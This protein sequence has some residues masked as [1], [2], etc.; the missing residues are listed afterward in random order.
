MPI[1]KSE[2]YSSLWKSCDELRGGMDASQYKDY[3]LVLLFVKYVSDKYAGQPDALIEVP[4]GG[5]FA[6]MI[7]LKG[8]KEIG[9]KVNKIIGKLAE[10]NELKGV[11]DV[12]DFNDA[13]KLGKGKEMVDRLSNLIAIFETPGLDFSRNRAEGDDILGDAYE[14]LMR[15]FATESGKSKG[16]FY[17]PAEVSRIMAKVIGIGNAKSNAETIYD[18]TCG[19]GSLLL[20]AHDEA[21]GSTRLDLAIYGQ[22]MDNATAALARMN[23]I[24]HDCPTAEIWQ[25][26]TLST[27]HFKEKE[28]GIKRHDYVVANP[29]FST[30]AWSN[31]FNPAEDQY[32][33]FEFGI[34][35]A[36]NGDYAFLLHIIKSLKSSGKGAVILP[37]GVLFRGGAEGTIRKNIIRKGYIKGIIGLPANLFYGTG[38]PACIIVLDKEQSAARS[39]IFMVD[40]SKGF[41]KDGNKNRLRHMDIHKI[42]DV[43]TRQIETDKYA[44]TVSLAEIEANDFNLNIPRYIDATEPEDIQ[45][46][47]AHLKGGIPNRDLAGLAPYWQ[48]CPGLKAQLFTPS[49]RPDYSRLSLETGSIK[50]TIFDNAE[51]AAFTRSVSV[52]FDQW[53]ATTTPALK[54]I[55]IGSHP[56]QLIEQI[57]EELLTVFNDLALIDRYDVYQ[58]LMSYWSEVMQDDVY[59]IASDGWL[60]TPDLIPS[61][62]IVSRYFTAEQQQ[63]EKLETERDAISRQMEELEEEH[64]GEEGLL[65][66]AKNDKGKVTKA[67]VKARL[68]EIK[69]DKDASDERKL[70]TDYTALIEAEAAANKKVKDAQKALDAK[71]EAK[72]ATLTVDEVKVLVVDD[73]WLATLG[74][75]VQ[76]E[77]DRVSQALTSRIRQLAERYATPLPQLTTEVEALSAKVDEHLQKMGFEL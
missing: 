28:G 43:F 19:S 30:K 34:P 75:D 1:K 69:H 46:I 73:K 70:L 55:S 53:R 42:V 72:Y 48:V 37:H 59:L 10:A 13:D 14:Y 64:S 31:G 21:K 36:K 60:G 12:A 15:H 68:T 11:I 74:A 47:E 25:D 57:A 51:F 49:D 18:P 3:V 7:A 16:Q 5:R 26:N 24:L 50:T 20:K 44:R 6:D 35:P 2:L 61:H 41:I 17:T 67:S 22:E 32:N 33:R 9:D 77:L 65:E 62:L 40:A 45:D 39:G 52:R 27:P 76:T 58:H 29:P 23:M 4:D 66:E 38:I 71:V 54:G 8:D 56:K 63:I